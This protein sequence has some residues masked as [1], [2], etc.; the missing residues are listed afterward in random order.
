MQGG[1]GVG[2]GGTGLLLHLML[3]RLKTRVGGGL[4]GRQCT[5]LS[6]VLPEK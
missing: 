6:P 2:V 3:T 1:Q 4:E 5:V